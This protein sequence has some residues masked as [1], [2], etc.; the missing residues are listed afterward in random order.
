MMRMGVLALLVASFACGSASDP[1]DLILENGRIITVNRLFTIASSM[2]I[3]DGK[4]VATGQ[5]DDMGVYRGPRTR[6]IDLGGKTVLPGLIDSHSHAASASIFEF[7]HPVPDMQTIEEVLEYVRSR[8]AALKDGEWIKV[9]QVFLTRLE[10]QRYP[11]RDELDAAAPLNPVIFETGPDASVSSLALEMSGIDEKWEVVDGG[12]GFVEKDPES[13]RLTG[14]LRSCTRYLKYQPPFPA[15]PP[16]EH[17]RLLRQLIRDYNRIGI[18]SIAERWAS[19]DEI[20][21]YRKLERR[22]ELTARVYISQRLDA[23]KPIREIRAQLQAM[24]ASPLFDK[25]GLVRVAAVKTFLD[26]GMLTGSAYMRYPWGV[27]RLYGISDPEYRGLLFITPEKLRQ[28]LTACFETDIQFTAHA[29]GDGAVHTFIDA[30]ENLSDRFDISTR[31]PVICH[32]NF[33]SEEAISGVARLG[34][35]V[36]IQ[37]AWLHL[38]GRTLRRQ[39]GDERLRWFQPLRSLFEAG[40]V[41][42]GGSDH[43]QKIGSRRSINFYDPWLAMWVASTREARWLDDPIRPEQALS[44]QQLIQFYTINNARLLQAEDDRGSLEPGKWAD[45]IVISD[46]LLSCPTEK[47]RD[48]EVEQTF[49]AGKL[50]YPR[51]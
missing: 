31:R 13:G 4:I 32:S 40:A 36:D 38:D 16:E 48:I 1:A 20:A 5:V 42:G 43:M 14:I 30:C 28:I 50:V 21:L 34:I 9:S 47:L 49:L 25:E 41:A 44:R 11:T 6:L 19:S 8:A 22:G 23:Q 24:A 27:S 51:D 15:P 7:D 35:G 29:V 39:F 26:G 18:T 17:S 10:E 37:P 46:D 3:K 12:P 45:F 2:A 33:M